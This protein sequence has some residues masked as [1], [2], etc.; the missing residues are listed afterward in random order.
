M[1]KKRDP[2]L[3]LLNMC[4]M[5]AVYLKSD[6][7]WTINSSTN[8]RRMEKTG[9]SVGG[10]AGKN[11]KEWKPAKLLITSEDLKKQWEKQNGKCHWLGIPLD[12]G[13]LFKDHPDWYQK[14]PGAPSV[15][16]IDESGDYTVDNIVITSRFANFGR[17]VYPYDKMVSFIETIKNGLK[18]ERKN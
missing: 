3:A 1:P 4:K 6:G 8:R 15:D 7:T 2:F 18:N 17:N 13:L 12:L 9:S 14:H 16:K 11:S 5:N 10:A